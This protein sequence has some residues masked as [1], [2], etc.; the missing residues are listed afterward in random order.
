M[1]FLNDETVQARLLLQNAAPVDATLR[2]PE[3]VVGCNC[4]RWG[5]PCPSYPN[6]GAGK[7]ADVPI[8]KKRAIQAA[9]KIPLRSPIKSIPSRR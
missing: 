5:H 8:A 7:K 6:Y 9:T 1:L 2:E 4:D 3:T